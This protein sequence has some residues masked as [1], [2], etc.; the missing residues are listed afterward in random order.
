MH[1]WLK[2]RLEQLKIITSFRIVP[3]P[4]CDLDWKWF[5]SNHGSCLGG[6]KNMGKE[7]SINFFVCM[8]YECKLT[9][10]LSFS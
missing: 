9:Y 6:Q 4:V 7:I 8:I 2:F 5:F 1:K 10:F 3:Y